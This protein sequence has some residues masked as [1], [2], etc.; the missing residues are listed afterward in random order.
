MPFC[1]RRHRH[2][3]AADIL[4]LAFCRYGPE[5]HRQ[6]MGS[7]MGSMTHVTPAEF[8]A[9]RELMAE[10]RRYCDFL[11]LAVQARRYRGPV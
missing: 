1:R 8:L 4:P 6:P 9:T 5:S 3:Q 2:A 11:G 10:P 7:N